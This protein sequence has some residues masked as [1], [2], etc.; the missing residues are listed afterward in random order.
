MHRREDLNVQEG[1]ETKT[2]GNSLRDEL[3]DG[4]FGARRIIALDEI[5]VAAIWVLPGWRQEFGHFS[6]IHPVGI[7][8]NIALR[9]LSKYLGELDGGW[10]TAGDQVCEH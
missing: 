4:L 7:D 6:A 10:H 9:G 3:D 1:V 2:L 8:D 5:E